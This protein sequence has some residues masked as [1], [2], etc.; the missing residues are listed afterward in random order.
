MKKTSSLF[1]VLF[2]IYF[3]FF[4]EKYLENNHLKQLILH[5]L[6]YSYE[7]LLNLYLKLK[8]FMHFPSKIEKALMTFQPFGQI[9]SKQ[10]FGL[11]LSSYK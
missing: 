8:I 3:E 7:F 5:R 10:T 4:L 6:H 2:D 11:F 1:T 9:A